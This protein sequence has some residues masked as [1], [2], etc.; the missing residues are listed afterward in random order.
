MAL[1][2]LKHVCLIGLLWAAMTHATLQAPLDHTRSN[3]FAR[4]HEICQ[5][6]AICRNVYEQGHAELSPSHFALLLQNLP[7]AR[8]ERLLVLA[9]RTDP[10]DAIAREQLANSMALYRLSFSEARCPPNTFWHWD[11]SQG[12]GVCRCYMDRDC[13]TDTLELCHPTVHPL[14]LACF[15]L[16]MLLGA[17]YIV[18]NTSCLPPSPPSKTS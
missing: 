6:H 13:R 7:N 15:L 14:L 9:Q 1:R 2:Y 18:L 4:L 5:E 17:I 3:Q 11:A 12:R 8:T 16:I 10:T